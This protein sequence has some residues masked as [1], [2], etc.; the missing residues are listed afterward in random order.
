MNI[1]IIPCH[2]RP[3][4]LA[5]CLERILSADGANEQFYLFA[6]DRG[7]DPQVLSVIRQFPLQH[8][9][10]RQP[11]HPYP[12]PSFNILEAYRVAFDMALRLGAYRIYLIEED[13]WIAKDFFRWHERVNAP[14]ASACRNQNLA[15]PP[16]TSPE[17]IYEHS[18]YQSLGV[19]FALAYVNTFLPWVEPGYY[20]DMIGYCREWFAPHGIPDANAEQDGLIHRVLLRYGFKTTY[21]GAPRAYHAGFTGSNREGAILEG[22]LAERIARLRTMTAEEMNA[23]APPEFADIVSCNL[24]GYGETSQRLIVWQENFPADEKSVAESV[25]A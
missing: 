15:E 11:N 19:S 24:E 22:S 9:V 18:S 4:F 3:D 7:F 6:V 12:G 14:I 2:R 1:V 10:L 5:V 16:T 25:P 8:T 17:E 13:I 20:R 23:L 21:A